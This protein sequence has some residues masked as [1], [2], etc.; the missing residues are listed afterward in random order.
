VLRITETVR[1]VKTRTKT[2]VK[3]KQGSKSKSK[4]T[5]MSRVRQDKK[6]TTVRD[7]Q[8]AKPQGVVLYRGPSLIDGS[9]I[10]CVATGLARPSKNPKTGRLI[11]TYILADNGDTPIDAWK[12]GTDRAICGDCPHR[13]TTC[14][15]DVSK[16]PT[17]VHKALNAGAYP[18]YDA[19]LHG[20]H[21]NGRVVRLGSYGDPAAVPL[22]VWGNVLSHAESWRGYTHQWETCDAGFSRHCMASVETPAQRER[23]LAKGFRTFRVRLPEQPLEEG[24]FICPASEEAGR[25]LT[26]EQCQACSGAKGGGRNATPAILFHGSS[27]AGNRTL[28]LYRQTMTALRAAEQQAQTAGRIPLSMLN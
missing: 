21:F 11:Q 23:A 15:V 2:T 18:E 7:K 8:P 4:T 1:L 25:R 19:K 5:E 20:R 10:V 6:R 24:E 16:G 17:A 3:L 12:S 14:Y 22:A 13:G 26:C 9:P 28:R 27:I